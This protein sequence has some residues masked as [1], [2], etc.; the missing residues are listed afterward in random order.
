MNRMSKEHTRDR[1]A[2]LMIIIDSSI[3]LTDSRDELLM[4]AC[5]MQQRTKELFDI[6]LGEE[7]R[8][9]MFKDLV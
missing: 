9:Q 6:T 4:L 8:K 7:G 5:A 2:E 3:R 1:M